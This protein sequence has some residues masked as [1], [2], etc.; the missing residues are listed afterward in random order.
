[1]YIYTEYYLNEY[2]S[3]IIITLI[4]LYNTIK[5]KFVSGKIWFIGNHKLNC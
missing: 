4:I 3:Y 2:I 1:M 5:Y